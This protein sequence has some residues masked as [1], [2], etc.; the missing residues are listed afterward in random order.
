GLM[1]PAVQAALAAAPDAAFDDA[2]QRRRGLVAAA[3]AVAASVATA[4]A[5]FLT[6][7]SHHPHPPGAEAAPTVLV[8]SCF[9]AA[10]L[11]PLLHPAYVR[12]GLL[13]AAVGFSSL[14]AT[15]H[16]ANH[17][18]PYTIGVLT[19]NLVFAVFVHALLAFP[20]GRLATRANRRLAVA[21]YLN[22]LAL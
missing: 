14:L 2:S 18:V 3:V 19:S 4:G 1:R 16:D 20:H 11:L 9:V 15:L 13:L 8:G 17:A 22:V 21:A 7:A 12:F 5:V 6:F 10:G